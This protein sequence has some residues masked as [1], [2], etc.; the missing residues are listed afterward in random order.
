MNPK[1]ANERQNLKSQRV[2]AY[3]IQAAKEMVLAEGAR[4]LSIRKVAERA[5][6]AVTTLYQYF[7]GLDELLQETKRVMIG[8]ILADMKGEKAELN[9]ASADIRRFCRVYMAYFVERPN[10]YEL[11]YAFRLGEDSMDG[12]AQLDYESLW[13]EAYS[14]LSQSEQNQPETT[15]TLAKAVIYMVHGLLSLYYSNNGMTTGTLYH[16]L[17]E[18]MN[19]LLK[20]RIDS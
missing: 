18:T 19:Y 4:N 14:C 16:E 20:G 9:S 15:V 7:L 8:D 3:F 10:V 12:L 13:R 17:E 5:G 1:E 6:Y 11:L 2:K